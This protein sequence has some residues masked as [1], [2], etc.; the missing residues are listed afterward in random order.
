VNIVL[1]NILG[2]HS[3]ITEFW[4]PLECGAVWIDE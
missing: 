2:K 1:C 3:G 4:S